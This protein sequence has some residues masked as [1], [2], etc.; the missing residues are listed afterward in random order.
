[1]QVV[2]ILSVILNSIGWGLLGFHLGQR[3]TED[4]MAGELENAVQEYFRDLNRAH[5]G[6]RENRGPSERSRPSEVMRKEGR[7]DES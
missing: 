5:G 3:Y 7:S 4:A 1:M 2:L 6:T